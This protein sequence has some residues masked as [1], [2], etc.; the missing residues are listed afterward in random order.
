MKHIVVSRK[1]WQCAGCGKPVL[2]GQPCFCTF[3]ATM[4]YGRY[5][6]SMLSRRFH[7]DCATT[8]PDR[9]YLCC[10]RGD[11]ELREAKRLMAEGA[12]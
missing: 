8:P 6:T 3:D 11:A 12:R 1:Q 7:L 4:P 9:A 2:S 10:V 5:I